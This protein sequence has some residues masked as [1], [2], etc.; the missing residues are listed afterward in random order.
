MRTF[1]A[2]VLLA[3]SLLPARAPA[4]DLK[5]SGHGLIRLSVPT[6]WSLTSHDGG[7]DGFHLRAKPK[8]GEAVVAR[9][10]IFEPSGD[11]VIR[12]QD[13]RGLLGKSVQPVLEGSVERAFDPKPL[14]LA[15]GTGWVVQFTD[16][17][18]VGKPAAPGEFKMVRSASATLD[19]RQIVVATILFDDA[20]RSEVAEAMSLLSSLRLERS[21]TV[22]RPPAGPFEFT[23]P[24]SEVVVKIPAIGLQPDVDTPNAKRYFRLSRV[25]SSLIVS[26]WLEPASSYAGLEAFWASER[27]SPAYAGAGA[28]ARVE[29]LKDGPWEVVAYEIPVPGGTSSHLRAERVQSGTWIDLHLST[30]SAGKPA[31]LR[32]ELLTALRAVQ[33]VEK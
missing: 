13:L 33:V 21:A 25:E 11:K 12:S 4:E 31:A 29:F 18:L 26:G 16:A 5:W 15:Q 8:A 24:E 17:S 23:V 14:A 20:S 32:D 19:G 9:I 27:R 22:A 1:A 30:T 3:A 10:T 6:G 7:E 2:A 28:P